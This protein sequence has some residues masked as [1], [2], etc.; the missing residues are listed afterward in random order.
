MS[1]TH[2]VG[3]DH[4]AAIWYSEPEDSLQSLIETFTGLDADDLIDQVV[5]AAATV[6]STG[7]SGLVQVDPVQE[8]ATLVR[9]HTPPGDP[10]AV[11]SWL[12][13]GPVL[14]T[15]ATRCHPIRLPRDSVLGH[16]GF[17]AVP[18][19]LATREEAYL[20]A[21]GRP[22]DHRDEDL[23]VRFATAA[24]RAMEAARGFEA[25]TRLLRSVH[26]FARRLPRLGSGAPGAGP[27]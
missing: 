3:L 12:Q 4:S 1:I 18:V 27:K 11:E 25:A 20:W 23:L 5:A 13:D 26:A 15:L 16:P 10:L 9:L 19:P 7:Y 6:C 24:G 17:L 8:S 2:Q 21:A 14:K 22:F